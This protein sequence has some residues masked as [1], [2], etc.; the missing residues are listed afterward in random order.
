MCNKEKSRYHDVYVLIIGAIIGFVLGLL[1]S[2]ITQGW[3]LKG[4]ELSVANN[5]R[6]NVKYELINN[7]GLARLIKE[8]LE[9]EDIIGKL[10]HESLT[11]KHTDQ[12]IISVG[13]E[14]GVL[15]S[16]IIKSYAH[17]FNMIQQCKAYRDMFVDSLR[18]QKD[19][20][21]LKGAAN[22]YLVEIDSVEKAGKELL[23]L[24]DKYYPEKN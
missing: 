5:L 22:A 7:V 14:I 8:D 13:Q 24:L 11:W 1:S 17:Y 18:G 3:I 20:K 15:K 12:V 2:C 16:D 19:I 9:K 10:R 4:K 6:G 21:E 23:E